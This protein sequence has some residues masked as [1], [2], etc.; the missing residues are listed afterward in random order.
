MIDLYTW[1]TS[2]GRKAT[3]MLEELGV[4]YN[5][6]PINIGK[7]EQFTPEYIK[8]NP[9]SKIPAII[10]QDGPGGKPF[11]LFES[12]AIL[13]YLAEKYGKLMPAETRARYITIQWL[14]FQ[15]G[16]IGPMFGQAHHF[17]RAAKEKVPYGIERY[18]TETRR[19]WGVLDKRLS[20]VPYVAGGDYT[21]ADIAIFPW[22][23]RY[24]WQGVALEEFPN[25]MR[26]YRSI[27]ARPAVQRGMELPA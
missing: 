24:E 3:I 20:A 5:I 8:I 10:D 6:H 9:N 27:E 16:G 26:W 11:T 1:K 25:A 17:R 14:M 13:M 22:C 12:G 21:I 19:L 7:D 4:P 23:A 2:N 15:M 18:T